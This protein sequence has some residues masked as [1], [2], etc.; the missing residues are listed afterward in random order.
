MNNFEE[1]ALPNILDEVNQAPGLGNRST[2][3]FLIPETDEEGNA[4]YNDDGRLVSISRTD[5]TRPTSSL[6]LQVRS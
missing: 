4:L 2:A 3:R 5:S 6:K 1:V